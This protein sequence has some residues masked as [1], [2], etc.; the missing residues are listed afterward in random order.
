MDISINSEDEILV[1]KALII[2]NRTIHPLIKFSTL[3]NDK[4]NLFGASMAPFALVVVEGKEKHV[5]PITDEE[6]DYEV[7]LEIHEF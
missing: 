4:G 7:L 2:G 6:F 5:I 1:G 3:K